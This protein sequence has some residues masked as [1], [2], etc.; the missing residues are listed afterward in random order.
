MISPP[1]SV[2]LEIPSDQHND[3]YIFGEDQPSL[4]EFERFVIYGGFNFADPREMA[5]SYDPTWDRSALDWLY[6]IQERF[7]TQLDRLAPVSYISNGDN[8]VVVTRLAEF[9][10]S[11]RGAI[12]LG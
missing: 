12:G 8:D 5:S 9:A 2:G 7:W 1:L 3:W 6:P 11:I 10:E 4:G